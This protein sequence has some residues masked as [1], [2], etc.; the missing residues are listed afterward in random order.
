M[1]NTLVEN[2][3]SISSRYSGNI[4]SP[5][6]ITDSNVTS[7]RPSRAAARAKTYSDEAYPPKC[8]LCRAARL[9]STDRA[10]SSVTPNAS[11]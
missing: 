4:L 3:A 11:T 9:S 10:A 2:V 6:L 7:R 5:Q 8:R 1:S